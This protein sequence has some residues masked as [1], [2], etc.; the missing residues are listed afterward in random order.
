MRPIFVASY[1]VYYNVLEQLLGIVVMGV[2]GAQKAKAK[3]AICSKGCTQPIMPMYPIAE[4]AT[5]C[6][7][8]PW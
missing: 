7:V 8:I 6:F 4:H 2:I 3:S 1:W 5:I